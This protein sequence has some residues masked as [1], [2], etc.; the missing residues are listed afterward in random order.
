VRQSV[1][2]YVTNIKTLLLGDLEKKCNTMR[3]SVDSHVKNRV[4]LL[5]LDLE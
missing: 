5:L 3:Q 2:R 1:D 4:T